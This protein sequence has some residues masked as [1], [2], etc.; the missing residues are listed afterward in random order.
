M[1]L[2]ATATSYR[3]TRVPAWALLL[4]LMTL[5]LLA[6]ATG[7]ALWG[8]F[9]EYVGPVRVSVRSWERVLALAAA[10]AV[11]R[12][13]VVTRPTLP[14]HL[15]ARVRSWE[16]P[17]VEVWAPFLSTRL[18]V[19]LVGYLAVVSVGFEPGTVRFRVSEN[20]LQ[21]LP[22]RWD[23]G[24]YLDIARDGYRWDGDAAREQNVVF[25][26]ALPMGMRALGWL[27]GDRWLLAGLL[28]ALASFLGAL[29][30]LHRLARDS[31]GEE[32]AAAA[33][34]LLST[35]PFAVYFS[36]PYTEALYLLA[37]VG[38]FHHLRRGEAGRAALWGLLVG[39][40]R[41]NGCFLVAPLVLL[42]AW[43]AWK[44]RRGHARQW[45]AATS[46]LAGVVSFSAFLLAAYGDPLAWARGQAAWE[47]VY[48]GLWP[49][50][51]ALV[52][53]RYAFI[54]GEG[55]YHYTAALPFDFMHSVAALLVLASIV[56]VARR[57]GV[58][59]A[60][61]VAVNILPPLLMGGVMSIGRMS[62]VLFP[63]FLWL[64]LA[65][66]ATHRTAWIA[67]F[68]ALQGLVAVLFFTWRPAF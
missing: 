25:F 28:I 8:G 67:A 13:V 18:G 35:Y 49:A 27:L 22:A 52:V 26:P 51:R 50:L 1:H 32:R 16:W 43:R 68:S 30:Y 57:L 12:H 11:L 34:W 38:A 41:P 64:A 45:L 44:E 21:N 31:I 10:A 17:G 59:M 42:V 19:L 29:V 58:P 15:W 5:L 7:V 54:A 60:V 4:D 46:P 48:V 40:C 39:F 63:L 47:R 37:A 36:A 9:R 20:E 6:V 66:P 65:I 62:S 2:N 61:F 3:S 53:D 33:V 24:W 55:L 14:E 23:A 56:P